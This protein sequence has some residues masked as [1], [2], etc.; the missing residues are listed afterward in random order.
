MLHQV[1]EQ[2]LTFYERLARDPNHRYRSWEH[3][4]VH[5]QQ[6]AGFSAS[7]HIDLAALHLAFYL[8]SWGMYRGSSVL[9]RKDYTIHRA[10]VAK[11]LEPAYSS[12]WSLEVADPKT[13]Q[14][15]N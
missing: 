5:F 4:F 2:V 11:L 8:A 14:W 15:R 6:R 1:R 12:L 7:Q 13:A 10:V 9:L 3:C